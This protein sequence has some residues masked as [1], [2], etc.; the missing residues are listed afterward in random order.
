MAVHPYPAGSWGPSEA[1][2]LIRDDENP[3]TIL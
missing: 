3:W 2:R 1:D